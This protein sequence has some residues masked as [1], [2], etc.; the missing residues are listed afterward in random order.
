MI[1]TNHAASLTL[2]GCSI[3]TNFAGQLTLTLFPGI[4]RHLRDDLGKDQWT[5]TKRLN[6]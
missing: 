5:K 3:D 6:G 1:D 4:G 2:N